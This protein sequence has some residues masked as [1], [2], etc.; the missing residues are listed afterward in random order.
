[1]T[2]AG[3]NPL[4]FQPPLKDTIS[5]SQTYEMQL[6]SARLDMGLSLS[7]FHEMP[8]NHIWLGKKWHICL[9]DVLVSYQMRNGRDSIINSI[10]TQKIRNK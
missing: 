7:D 10:Q 3:M 9:A 1:M 4:T 2:V 6:E 5:I 8:G